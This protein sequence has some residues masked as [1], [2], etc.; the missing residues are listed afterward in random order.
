MYP[1]QVQALNVINLYN[2]RE[3][4]GPETSFSRRDILFSVDRPILQTTCN[5]VTLP[6]ISLSCAHS[7]KV[8]WS[9]FAA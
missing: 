8:L 4:R 9:P 7:I 3:G 5:P 2:W 6:M 1:S